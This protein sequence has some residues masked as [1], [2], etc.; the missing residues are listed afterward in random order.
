MTFLK[1]ED[2]DKSF[3]KNNVI[4]KFNLEVEKTCMIKMHTRFDNYK[5]IEIKEICPF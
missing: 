4:S 3:D 2:I 1:F 5:N